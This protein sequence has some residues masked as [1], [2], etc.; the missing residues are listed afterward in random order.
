M[1]AAYQPRFLA[2][3]PVA[4]GTFAFA[5]AHLDHPHI[6]DQCRGLISA[7][8]ALTWVFD[9]A[10]ERVAAFRTVFPQARAARSFEEILT[11]SEVQ[12]VTAAAIPS[13]RAEIGCRVMR[14]G[15]DYLTDKPPFTTLAQLEDTRRVAADT[16]R[17]YA[18]FYGDRLG[19]ECAV[20]AG[21][22]IQEGALGRV[23]QV[24]G[25]GPHRLNRPNRPAWFFQ[26]EHYGGILC[27]LGSHQCDKFLAYTGSTDA[28]VLHAAVAN[29]AN[30]STP[31]LEDYGEAS[32]LGSSG[33]THH[34]RVDWLTPDGQTTWGDGR[35]FILGTHGT[36]ELRSFCDVARSSKGELLILVDAEGEHRIECA[37]R[38]GLPFYGEL[39]R[40]CLQRTEHAQSQA[41]AF[42]AAELCL[43]T[44]AAAQRL[45][46]PA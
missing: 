34:H 36:I 23:L 16:R 45:P 28:E 33:A 35:T 1:N 27:D 15:K 20:H 11:D 31:E 7:G 13:R 9:S 3:P 8:A 21:R 19:V 41:H 39:V 37:G 12:L 32:L 24:I 2:P 26:R 4:A 46:S 38:V 17:K 42:K 14:A 5:A 30:P 43:R 44:Q 18:I 29:H 10:P 25:L 22:L 40:D 6:Y